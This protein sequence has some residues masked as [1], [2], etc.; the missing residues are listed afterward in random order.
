MIIAAKRGDAARVAELARSS[1]KKLN[2]LA[3]RTQSPVYSS[4]EI[5][6]WIP[7]YKAVAQNPRILID[8]IKDP[9]VVIPQHPRL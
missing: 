2:Y 3:R 7:E 5:M 9:K 1:I 8:V 6:S 4:K